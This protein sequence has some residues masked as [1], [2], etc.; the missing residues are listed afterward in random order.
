MEYIIKIKDAIKESPFSSI[1]RTLARPIFWCQY[2]KSDLCGWL[3]KK[4]ISKPAKYQYFKVWK[5]SHMGETCFVVATGP[6]L[7]FGDLDVLADS[8]V[9]CFGMNSCVLALD[10]T[11]WV[12]DILGIEDE[13]VYKKI[14]PALIEASKDKLKGKIWVSDL[15]ASIFKSAKDFYIYPHHYLDHKYNPKKILELKFSDDLYVNVFDG[16]SV[17]LS[18]MQ[19][20]VYMGFKRICLIGSDCN[21][22][23]T[24]K[25]FI[26]HGA[27]KKFEENDI[28]GVRIIAAHERFKEFAELH[29]VEV[30][31]C[32]RG[33]MLEV[34]PR[35]S[36]EEVLGL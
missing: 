15:M 2:Q 31:N 19:L 29:G 33:G 24:K 20:A 5:N 28:A 35:K 12:P 23:Q 17:A 22:N 10:K 27:N 4:G 21:Y 14:E 7:T 3:R 6:S 18:V 34:Y 32:T 36:L 16:Y 25:N 13:F 9:F 8:G 26:E 1:I 11:K 30:L